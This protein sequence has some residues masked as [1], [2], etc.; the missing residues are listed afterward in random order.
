MGSGVGVL[1]LNG[2]YSFRSDRR[3]KVVPFVT[4]GYSLLFRSGHLNAANFGGGFSYWF[5]E[6]AGLRFEFRD[7][8]R[9]KYLGSHIVQGRIGVIFR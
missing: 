5:S 7:Y 8:V 3:S 1:S 6:K 9:P 4:G 2:L